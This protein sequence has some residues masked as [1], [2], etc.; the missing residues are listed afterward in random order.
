M[1][2]H[3][4]AQESK[5]ERSLFEGKGS[6][7]WSRQSPQEEVSWRRVA[8]HWLSRASLSLAE[9]C[10]SLIGWA[11]AR[12][13]ENSSSFLTDAWGRWQERLFLL[14]PVLPL[15]GVCMRA[16]PLAP[17]TWG[18]V[19]SP[20]FHVHFFK[21][22]RLSFSPILGARLSGFCGARDPRE[23]GRRQ[24][25]PLEPSPKVKRPGPP[26][27]RLHAHILPAQCG[28]MTLGPEVGSL[29]P[30]WRMAPRC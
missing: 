6:G 19:V 26:A 13:G 28:R 16:P 1:V 27:P 18:G 10:E 2:N 25:P 29:G 4:Q 22:I 11:V 23:E 3:M 20:N 17:Y 15:S 30:F 9:S 8:A 5:G 14:E 12:Q 24:R 21:N 7:D